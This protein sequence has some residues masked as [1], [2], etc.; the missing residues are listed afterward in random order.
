MKGGALASAV[1]SFSEHGDPYITALVRHIMVQ[2]AKPIYAMLHRYSHLAEA[3][4][5]SDVKQVDI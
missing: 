1:F 5:E 2:I 4:Y 3:V